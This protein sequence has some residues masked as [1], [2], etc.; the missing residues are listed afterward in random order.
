M[1]SGESRSPLCKKYPSIKIELAG[2]VRK[3]KKNETKN[4]ILVFPYSWSFLARNE[5]HF[6]QTINKNKIDQDFCAAH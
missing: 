4:K 2:L 1:R 3:F 6:G 5:P